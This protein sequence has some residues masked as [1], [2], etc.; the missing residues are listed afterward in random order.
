MIRTP[1]FPRIDIY[2]DASGWWRWQL[3]AANGRIIADGSEGYSERR[4]AERAMYAAKLAMA[5]SLVRY[6]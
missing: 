1:R 4:H 2:R 5:S 3:R 6:R